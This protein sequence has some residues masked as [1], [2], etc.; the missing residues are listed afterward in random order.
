MD[1][2]VSGSGTHL[3]LV[4]GAGRVLALTL[5]DGTV[6]DG[7]VGMMTSAPD[8]F[9]RE[10]EQVRR[11]G[12]KVFVRAPAEVEIEEL[13]SPAAVDKAMAMGSRQ[14]L[15]DLTELAAFWS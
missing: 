10:L 15:D 3:D 13:M 1:G 2:G 9:L 6:E 12:T 4:A 7:V 8:G 5:T 11:S 14:A